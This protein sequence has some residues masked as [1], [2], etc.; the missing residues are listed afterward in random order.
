M[1]D[2]VQLRDHSQ[3]CEHDQD[4][5]FWRDTGVPFIA[6]WCCFDADCPGGREL[7]ATEM[8]WCST[9]KAEMHGKACYKGGA[10]NFD[11]A[12][13]RNLDGRLCV[14]STVL[15]VEEQHGD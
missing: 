4:A 7:T 10:R 12:V 13:A 6:H 14:R 5:F 8:D 2:E 1:S 11:E 3:P 9:H 15:I